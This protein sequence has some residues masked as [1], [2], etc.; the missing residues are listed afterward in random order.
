MAGAGQHKQER[1]HVQGEKNLSKFER[2]VEIQG[3]AL[4]SCFLKQVLK[5]LKQIMRESSEEGCVSVEGLGEMAAV[6]C[7]KGQGQKQGS[8]A[9]AQSA[10]LWLIFSAQ[11]IHFSGHVPLAGLFSS[12]QLRSP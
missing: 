11:L 10:Y 12:L 2:K 1:W 6:R 7:C 4:S 9:L 8:W 3:S 5:V